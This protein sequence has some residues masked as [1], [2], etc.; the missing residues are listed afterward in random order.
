MP[1]ITIQM[2][3]GRDEE[4]KK[5]VAQAVLEAASNALSRGKEHFSVSIKDVPQDE[6]KAKV[7]DKVLE[8]K[9]TFIKP[10]YEM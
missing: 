7:Y 1:H 10:G 8:D 2:Y 6:W 4:T 9:D 3:P 5:K